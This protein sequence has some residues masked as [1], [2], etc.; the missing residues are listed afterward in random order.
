M[1]CR[2]TGDDIRA[3]FKSWDRLPVSCSVQALSPIPGEGERNLPSLRISLKKLK[4]N[5]PACFRIRRRSG[6][7]A[8][9]MEYPDSEKACA[10]RGSHGAAVRHTGR[11]FKSRVGSVT[12]FWRKG[13]T[14][15]IITVAATPSRRKQTA[16]S[17]FAV[18]SKWMILTLS[19]SITRL[20]VNRWAF[21]WR[22]K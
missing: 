2:G 19:V 4:S 20:T 13:L 3:L 8:A 5:A 15:R 16:S 18:A 9:A 11:F 12:M 7:E 21:W 22:S 14:A 10:G 1:R 6:T 17:T